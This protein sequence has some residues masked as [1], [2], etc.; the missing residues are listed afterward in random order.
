MAV[1]AQARTLT[2]VRKSRENHLMRAPATLLILG[3]SSLSTGCSPP[4]IDISISQENG[5]STVHIEQ[6]WGIFSRTKPPC[7]DQISLTPIKWGYPLWEAKIPESGNCI[8]LSSFKFGEV[9]KGFAQA[10]PMPSAL[11]RILYLEVGGIGVGVLKVV[12]ERLPAVRY[13]VAAAD[14]S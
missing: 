13:S 7:V 10:R 6:D 14:Q 4:M 2:L 5:I 9:P 8:H 3:L 12:V 11:P 1:C